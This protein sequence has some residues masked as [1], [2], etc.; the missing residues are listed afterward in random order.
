MADHKL[1]E[2]GELILFG[3]VGGDAFFDDGFEAREVV[4]ALAKLK[5]DITVR[6]NSWGGVVSDGVAIHNALK[7]HKGKVTVQVDGIAA[8]AASVIAMAGDEI[9]VPEN[10]TLMVHNASSIT[11]GTKAD[12]FKQAEVLDKFDGQLAGIFAERTGLSKDGVSM[13]MNAETWMT[14]SEAVAK[15]FADSAPGSDKT[16]EIDARVL[17]YANAPKHLKAI[18][19]NQAGFTAHKSN[20]PV[21]NN[22]KESEMTDE[23]KAAAE[24][25]AKKEAEVKVK[26]AA[27]DK[28]KAVAKA[29]ADAEQAAEVKVKAD[30]ERSTNITTV[31]NQSGAPDKAADYINSGKSLEEISLELIAARAKADEANTITAHN[32]TREEFTAGWDKVTEAV[33]SRLN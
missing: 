6:I 3:T 2:N 26:A 13:L 23:T 18:A 7:N 14:G 20:G 22:E 4:T 17:M 33:N 27:E 21:A 9:I 25:V 1:I 15:G 30:R 24:A 16:P 11:I 29:T 19:K 12:H 5:G 31:C 28:A 8:S 10:S 32:Q